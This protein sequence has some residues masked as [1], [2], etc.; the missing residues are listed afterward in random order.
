MVLKLKDGW[1]PR[2]WIREELEFINNYFRYF[3]ILLEIIQTLITFILYDITVLKE[4]NFKTSGNTSLPGGLP[5]LFPFP[6]NKKENEQTAAHL[7]RSSDKRQFSCYG[8]I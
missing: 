8:S 5:E 1:F 3:I 4:K 2:R 6:K 7:T